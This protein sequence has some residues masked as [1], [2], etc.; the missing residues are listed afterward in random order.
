MGVLGVGDG[1]RV[2]DE[3]GATEGRWVG[4]IVGVGVG[5]SVGDAEGARVGGFGQFSTASISS[6]IPTVKGYNTE[7]PF[8]G[9]S[10]TSP[11]V[12]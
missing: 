10:K 8:K 1:M 3:V 11:H 6:C 12:L 5:R 7:L 2:G 9:G 4:R